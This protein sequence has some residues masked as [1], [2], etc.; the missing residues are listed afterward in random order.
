MYVR[1]ILAAL[2]AAFTLSGCDWVDDNETEH[3]EAEGYVLSSDGAEIARLADARVTG[4]IDVKAG[5][6]TRPLL[7]TLTDHD[8][9]SIPESRLGP[10]FTLRWE[11]RNPSVAEVR[12]DAANRWALLVKGL[13]ADST[14]VRIFL[15]HNGHDDLKT[16][17][18]GIPIFVTP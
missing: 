4:R 3:A 7:L 12:P 11:I 9:K 1:P 17:P 8:G 2:I 15:L 18:A 16:P 14:S 6:E 13:K 10:E 5:A